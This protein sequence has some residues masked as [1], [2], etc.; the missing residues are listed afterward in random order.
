M[1][2]RYLHAEFRPALSPTEKR[3]LT[4]LLDHTSAEHDVW[5][6][7]RCS[8]DA[9]RQPTQEEQQRLSALTH[10]FYRTHPAF[11]T[12]AVLYAHFNCVP[13]QSRYY[14]AC[15][16][17]FFEVVVPR[18]LACMIDEHLTAARREL[19]RDYNTLRTHPPIHPLRRLVL[20]AIYFIEDSTAL[21]QGTVLKCQTPEEVFCAELKVAYDR[22]R[23]TYQHPTTRH[24]DLMLQEWSRFH[25]TYALSR[26]PAAPC[27]A[28][29]G[30][31]QSESR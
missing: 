27:P 22:L 31:P 7:E 18:A 30:T 28:G 16:E 9:L 29:A 4:A 19:Y 25:T 17:T 8:P 15:G 1:A 26:S 10:E 24:L 6:A 20:S 3:E 5:I 2:S 21:L 11:W 14:D 12:T 13:S 23:E